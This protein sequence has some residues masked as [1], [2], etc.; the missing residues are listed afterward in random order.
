MQHRQEIDVELRGTSWNIR[1]QQGC[2]YHQ[3]PK[4]KSQ[5]TLSTKPATQMFKAK[6]L[7]I[8]ARATYLKLYEISPKLKRNQFASLS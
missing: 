3:R 6:S 7:A 2:K 5:W 1:I 8:P 4:D